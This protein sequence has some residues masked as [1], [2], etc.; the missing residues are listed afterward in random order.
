LGYIPTVSGRVLGVKSSSQE[1]QMPQ[2]ISPFH[3][4]AEDFGTF[5]VRERAREAQRD[6]RDDKIE[7]PSEN[8][9]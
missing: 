8:T 3:E 1:A 6:R 5:V 7:R 2:A 4:Q 9:D